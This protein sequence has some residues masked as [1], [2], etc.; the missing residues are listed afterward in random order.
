METPG[1]H[2][3]GTLGFQCLRP[4]GWGCLFSAKSLLEVILFNYILLFHPWPDLCHFFHDCFIDIIHMS[5]S[6]PF[7]NFS[8]FAELCNHHYIISEH[9]YH[10]QK[11]PVPLSGPSP[12]PL[13][14]SAP[15]SH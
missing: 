8:I 3:C 7:S 11:T 10:P 15:G 4:C 13:S 12:S 1:S 6:L 2:P 9:F 5:Y 14:S